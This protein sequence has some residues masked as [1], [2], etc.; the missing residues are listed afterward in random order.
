VYVSLL[1]ITVV[2]A[3]LYVFALRLL[4]NGTGIRE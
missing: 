3:A 2:A 1:M 4:N